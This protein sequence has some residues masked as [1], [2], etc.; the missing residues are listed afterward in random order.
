MSNLSL[1]LIENADLFS[2]APLG[3]RTVSVVGGK[4][5]GIHPAGSAKDLRLHLE[6]VC[7][8]VTVLDAEGGKV[9]LGI[10][11]RYVHFNGAGGRGRPPI[12]NSAAPALR[13]HPSRGDLGGRAHGDRRNLPGPARPPDEGSWAGG[14]GTEHLDPDGQ[15]CLSL[16]DS[17]GRCQ[18]TFFVL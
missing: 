4:I 2:P 17:D 10:I 15:L 5:S 16:P 3:P 12:P 18:N 8:E 9:M 6:Q 14:G 1:L 7:P 11:D 13:I